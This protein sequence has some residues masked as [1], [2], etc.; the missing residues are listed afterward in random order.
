MKNNT[1]TSIPSKLN[2]S[3]LTPSWA[4]KIMDKLC[5]FFQVEKLN[6]IKSLI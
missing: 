3:S 4:T 2:L 5:I 6:L 1:E